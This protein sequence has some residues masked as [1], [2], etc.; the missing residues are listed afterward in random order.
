MIKNNHLWKL[1]V[2][3]SLEHQQHFQNTEAKENALGIKKIK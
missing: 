3:R 1:D 2:Q